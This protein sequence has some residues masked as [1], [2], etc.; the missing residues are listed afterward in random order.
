MIRSQDIRFF[1]IGFLGANYWTLRAIQHDIASICTT[2]I[3][4]VVSF[5]KYKPSPTDYKA[6]IVVD[7]FEAK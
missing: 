7:F 1:V 3:V 5:A 4:V 2:Y 6:R